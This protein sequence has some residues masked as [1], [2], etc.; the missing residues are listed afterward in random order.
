QK[1]SISILGLKFAFA[2]ITNL[3]LR[4][5]VE[6]WLKPF[7]ILLTEPGRQFGHRANLMEGRP[8]CRPK[9][10]ADATERVPPL[11]SH[12]FANVF[13]RRTAVGNHLIVVFLQTEILPRFFLSRL[14]K[15]E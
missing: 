12:Q 3:N 4:M 15:I 6:K 14:A 11:Q 7:F 8:P 2:R 1:K 9:Y 13:Y 5:S 10:S